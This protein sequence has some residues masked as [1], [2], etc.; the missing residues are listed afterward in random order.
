LV[1]DAH[2]A[3][4]SDHG[5]D[6]VKDGSR[7]TSVINELKGLGIRVSLFMD[8]DSDGIRTAKQLNADRVELYTEPFAKAFNTQHNLDS[9]MQKYTDAAKTAQNL[10]LGL[11]AGHDLN[12]QNLGFFS[13]RIPG[14]LE[15][16]IG[17]ALIA[18]A[19]DMGLYNTVK[20]YLEILEKNKYCQ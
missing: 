8:P 6:L 17:H 18:D 5:W 3:S 9:I 16:S 13:S 11:N 7:L 14:L 19:I 20:A 2:D 1:P 15:V 10:G 12:L 4:T